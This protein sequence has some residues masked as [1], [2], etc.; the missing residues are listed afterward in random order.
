M[1]SNSKQICIRIQTCPQMNL[2]D[3]VAAL[4]NHRPTTMIKYEFEKMW[5][6]AMNKYELM[7][8]GDVVAEQ[9]DHK[10]RHLMIG[11]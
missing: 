4:I 11:V 2:G 6:D 5:I 10:G 8:L 9:P 7:N 1:H 3:V